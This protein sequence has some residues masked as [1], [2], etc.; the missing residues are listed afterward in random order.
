[1]FFDINKFPREWGIVVFPI[2]MTRIG[3]VQSPSECIDALYFLKQKISINR[4]GANFLYSDGLY[5]NFEKDV[6]ETKNKFAQNTVSH[7]RGV[8]NLIKKHYQDFQI[9]SAFSFES[10]F[11]MY[12]SHEDFFNAFKTVK[13]LYASD[14]KFRKQVAL[15]AEE[16]GKE[17]NEC[18]ISFYLE[19]HTF[20]YLILNRELEL[21]NNFV[22]GQE[23]WVLMAYPGKPPRGQIYLFQQDPLKI[24]SDSNPYKG[25][26]DLV[27]KKFIDYNKVDLDSF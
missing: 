8:K 6:Y 7:M 15:D 21:R 12:L 11:Q 3:N 26:Y 24:N 19:E 4:T 1:M 22:N 25:Q 17:L 16:Q 10:W 18:Q 13:D 5:M 23:Q 14:E 20:G 27:E 9:E 2:S